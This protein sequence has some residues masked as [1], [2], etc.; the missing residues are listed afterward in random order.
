[1][2]CCCITEMSLRASGGFGADLG[3]SGWI[4]GKGCPT[5]NGTIHYPLPFQRT[6]YMPHTDELSTSFDLSLT[7]LPSHK[8][9]FD[10]KVVV[11]RK[12]NFEKEVTWSYSNGPHSTCT[13]GN[14][15]P[16]DNKDNKI[17]LYTV[18]GVGLILVIAGVLFFLLRRKGDVYVPYATEPHLE[19]TS[20]QNLA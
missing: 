3:I 18:L 7:N 16:Q 12:N 19:G 13:L 11:S 6:V 2:D 8:K 17:V 9:L 20:Y 15:L 5:A 1:M 14:R 10:K 4:S